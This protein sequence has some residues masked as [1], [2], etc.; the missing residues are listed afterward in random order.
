M[1]QAREILM[2]V[3]P[4][5][6]GISL[7]SCY[8][9]TESYKQKTYATKR[10]DAGKN[11][12]ARISLQCRPRTTVT[13]NVINLHWTKNI[14]L[15]LESTNCCKSD[16]VVDSKDAKTIM[17]RHSTSSESQKKLETNNLS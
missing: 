7:S 5:G 6:L 12:N 11:V 16:C 9:Y 2:K 17:W 4:L 8:N 15:I 10:Y 3:S 13:K 1:Q 14:N